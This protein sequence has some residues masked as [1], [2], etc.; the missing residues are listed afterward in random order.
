[1]AETYITSK[2]AI[3][4]MTI[5]IPTGS[6]T[7]TPLVWPSDI[8]S[9]RTY[10]G[11]DPKAETSVQIPGNLMGAIATPG[12]V[13]RSP[14]MVTLPYS[15][16]IDALR[17]QIEMCLNYAATGSYT[18]KDANGNING[19]TTTRTGI[20]QSSEVSGWDATKGEW[21]MITLTMECDT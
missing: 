14:V 11:G 6:G 7:I 20:L 4:W 16:A 21:T 5:N 19:Q 8:K 3:I 1:M 12:P 2:D 9:F 15:V 18:P 10:K 17:P 13:K